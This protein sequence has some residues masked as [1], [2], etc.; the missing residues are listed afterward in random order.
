MIF[1]DLI[2][3]GI[4]TTITNESS[5]SNILFEVTRHDV[6]LIA[7]DIEIGDIDHVITM[8]LVT[9]IN[10]L[11][12][13]STHKDLNISRDGLLVLT[14]LVTLST[15]VLRASIDLLSTDAGDRA[16]MCLSQ[17]LINPTAITL[18]QFRSTR[19]NILVIREE[20]INAINTMSKS[21]LV[22][23]S[24]HLD[25]RLQAAG[26]VL[27]KLDDLFLISM[28][29]NIRILVFATIKNI[30]VHSIISS[31]RVFHS[32]LFIVH[33]VIVRFISIFQSLTDKSIN[34][35]L[36]LL[37]EGIEN[38]LNGLFLLRLFFLFFFLGFHRLSHIG[39]ILLLSVGLLLRVSLCVIS[40]MLK[41]SFVVEI[42]IITMG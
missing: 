9:A 2:G 29:E 39:L 22:I 4:F 24:E 20:I 6:S 14:I 7:N 13:S 25:S 23:L 33:I 30:S 8:E 28:R 16:L 36:L 15:D 26:I 41:R 19:M 32:F 1:V 34:N 31:F 3:I 12:I 42:T 21:I 27:S 11:R 18:E 17:N 5:Q 37:S 35:S 38:V 40:S 10:G